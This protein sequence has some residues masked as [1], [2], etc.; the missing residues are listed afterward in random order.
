MLYRFA[1]LLQRW[2]RCHIMTVGI[3]AHAGE[4]CRFFSSQ[5]VEF[6]NILH[7][8]PKKGDAPCAVFIMGGEDFQ[9]IPAHAKIA[10]LKGGIIAFILQRHQLAD[11]LLPVCDLPLFQVEN[12]RRIGFNRP[13]AIDAGNRG[14]D[15]HIIAFEQ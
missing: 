4:R 11:N 2:P 10:A 7:L 14:D 8:V 13:D 5:R 15:D 12:H 1:R 3:N 6:D 9:T